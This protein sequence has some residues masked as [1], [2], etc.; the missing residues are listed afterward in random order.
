M[1]TEIEWYCC[2]DRRGNLHCALVYRE[3]GHE[4]SNTFNIDSQSLAI[5][6]SVFNLIGLAEH[7]AP[8]ARKL[9]AAKALGLLMPETFSIYKH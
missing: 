4:V 2:A 8:V 1:Q 3:G 7:H 5:G 6:Y 9:L